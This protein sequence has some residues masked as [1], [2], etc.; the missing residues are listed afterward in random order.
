MFFKAISPS[1]GDDIPYYISPSI[2]FTIVVFHLVKIRDTNDN[3]PVFQQS[4]YAISVPITSQTIGKRLLKV[5]AFDRDDGSNGK[6][7]Y[8]LERSRDSNL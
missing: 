1:H 5:Q 4:S 8:T 6:V 3:V 2:R 7:S